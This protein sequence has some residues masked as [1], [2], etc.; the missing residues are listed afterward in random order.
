MFFKD[1]VVYNLNH[2]NGYN[3]KRKEPFSAF[4]SLDPTISMH[5]S[6]QPNILQSKMKPT[7]QSLMQ[8]LDWLPMSWPT[9][10]LGLEIIWLYACWLLNR[11]FCIVIE[12]LTLSYWHWTKCTKLKTKMAKV[13][14]FLKLKILKKLIWWLEA[15]ACRYVLK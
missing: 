8:K 5:F 7:H 10:A 15:A 1:H 4:P 9:I 14:I 2:K 11:R 6:E 3:F 13:K 12:Q